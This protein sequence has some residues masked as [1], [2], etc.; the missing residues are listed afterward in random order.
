MALYNYICPECGYEV[1]QMHSM[2]ECNDELENPW[3]NQ[4]CPNC[5]PKAGKRPILKRVVANRPSVNFMGVGQKEYFKDDSNFP[6]SVD[7]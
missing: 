5:S 3:N 2:K 7:E 1:T 4:E 6:D